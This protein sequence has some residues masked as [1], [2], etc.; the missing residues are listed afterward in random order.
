MNI[1]DRIAQLRKDLTEEDEGGEINK[2]SLE[3]FTNFTQLVD[4]DI[5]NENL[6]ISLTPDN[7]IYAR[8]SFECG[9]YSFHFKGNGEISFVKLRNKK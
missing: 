3:D 9:I 6:V 1:E 5:V 8:W 2:S 7:D 4:D